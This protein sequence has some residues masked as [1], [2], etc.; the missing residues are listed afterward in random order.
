[1]TI[2]PNHNLIDVT[3]HGAAGDG[4]T[5]DTAAVRLAVDAASPGDT[6]WFPSGNYLLADTVELKNDLT[7][8]GHG[9]IHSPSGRIVFRAVVTTVGGVDTDPHDISIRNLKF[10]GNFAAGRGCFVLWAHR[11]TNLNI[12]GIEVDQAVASGHVADLQ[13]CKNVYIAHS[14]IRGSTGTRPEAEAF[15]IE[16]SGMSGSPDKTFP[17]VYN[18]QACDGV[19]IEHCRFEPWGNYAAPRAAGS[20]G[21]RENRQITNIVIRNNVFHQPITNVANEN[22]AFLNFRGVDICE[23]Y[24]NT[25]VTTA[26]EM[27]LV[28]RIPTT[29]WAS[30]ASVNQASPTYVT[31]TNNQL[32]LGFSC[33][34]NKVTGPSA[35]QL[36]KYDGVGTPV[37]VYADDL[38]A[39]SGRT[40][41]ATRFGTDVVVTG[42]VYVTDSAPYTAKNGKNIAQIP[43]RWAP[44]YNA[45]NAC[46]SQSQSTFN[47]VCV[48]GGTLSVRRVSVSS[49]NYE[50]PVVFR[51]NLS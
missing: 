34:N 20:H 50:M 33:F 41:L 6:V 24:D 3:T 46:I 27:R 4:V 23:I 9:E 51:W 47:A 14:I 39:T 12:T 10:H 37:T 17:Q 36:E 32:T 48:R 30:N 21:T 43:P 40:L 35:D 26:T 29:S 42:T 11:V 31:T 2:D 25:F 22:T 45:Y 8:D 38:T 19:T 28:K 15:Q 1:M 7:I 16:Y 5:D 13:G 18:A 49:S 44:S